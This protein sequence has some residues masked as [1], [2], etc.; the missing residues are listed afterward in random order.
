MKRANKN[1][2]RIVALM[3]GT[4][5]FGSERGNIEAY[6]ALR[7]AGAD[8]LVAISSREPEGGD[9]GRLI[10][11]LEFKTVYFPYGGRWDRNQMA[12][13]KSY[14]R[15]QLKRL[16]TNSK[17]L[18]DT[19]VEHQAT[20]VML[21]SPLAFQ[22]CAIAL[23]INRIPLI[24]RMGDAP[25]KASKFQ[26]WLWKWMARRA[27]RIVAISHFIAST[28][29]Q[30]SYWT[31][32]KITVIH[33]ALLTRPTFE[34][35]EELRNQLLERKCPFQL[36]YVGQITPQ[37]G[38]NELID[39]LIAMDSE[40]IGCWIVGGSKYTA[41]YEAELR[42]RVKQ[43]HTRTRIDFFGFQSNPT[44]YYEAADWHIVPSK[45]EEPLGNVV[46]EAKAHR[47]PSIVSPM[48]GLPELIEHGVDGIILSDVS[49]AAIKNS[50]YKLNSE[51][52]ELI[53]YGEAA[54][55]SLFDRLGKG[56]FEEKWHH[57]ING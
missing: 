57:I 50:I 21:G 36:I 51:Q 15:R 8:V 43:S 44:A 35:T 18:L 25:V 24:Y 46:Q 31:K 55:S 1:P 56:A 40:K 37:K 13:L 22:Y 26:F 10:Q 29:S 19:I 39:A 53:K 17:L 42:A 2:I 11:E 49:A 52:T 9:A 6:L 12:R 41:T 45:Y 30:H 14:R 20:H 34:S 5:L 16:W 7:K 47:T 28:A 33:N 4:Q 48:G 3:P 32:K 54:Y 23:T 27:N 38:I